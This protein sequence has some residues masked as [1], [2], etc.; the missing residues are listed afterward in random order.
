MR[1]A[2]NTCMGKM[3][4]RWE[5]RWQEIYGEV[6]HGAGCEGSWASGDHSESEETW[7]GFPTQQ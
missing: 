7:G 6:I 3:E 2:F 1:W 4:V 5:Q